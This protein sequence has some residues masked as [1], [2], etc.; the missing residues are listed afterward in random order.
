MSGTEA[1]C[2]QQLPA[3]HGLPRRVPDSFCQDPPS[4]WSRC[5]PSPEIVSN[6]RSQ[7][8]HTY[9]PSA[10]RCGGPLCPERKRAAQ[11]LQSVIGPLGPLPL[12]P[13]S[14]A[15]HSH[16]SHR[17]M[18]PSQKRRWLASEVSDANV[19]LQPTQRSSPL[20]FCSSG[21]VCPARYRDE[22]VEQRVR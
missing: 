13:V 21:P 14:S 18:P 20:S 1:P 3:S 19:R 9:R 10:F 16:H 4:Q 11:E 5:E 12:P 22:H 8:E 15:L 7:C 6:V 17:H 2:G